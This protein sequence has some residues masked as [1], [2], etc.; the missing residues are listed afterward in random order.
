MHACRISCAA[1]CIYS[2][3]GRVLYTRQTL[4]KAAT[5][6]KQHVRFQLCSPIQA[7]LCPLHRISKHLCCYL[8]LAK[9]NGSAELIE[10][11]EVAALAVKEDKCIKR[12]KV[13]TAHSNSASGES[14]DHITQLAKPDY[15]SPKQILALLPAQSKPFWQPSV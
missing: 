5:T 2:Y 1:G 15:P 10:E 11:E 14:R 12:V 13:P 8:Q 4:L 3:I 9:G 7:I 6:L